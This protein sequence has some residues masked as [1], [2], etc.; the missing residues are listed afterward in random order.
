MQNKII[1]T[2]KIATKLIEAGNVPVGTTPNPSKP[3]FLCWIFAETPKFQSDF[4]KIVAE[5]RENAPKRTSFIANAAV[6]AD[7]TDAE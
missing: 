3:N 4:A 5:K 1:Y 7:D 2:R 6:T